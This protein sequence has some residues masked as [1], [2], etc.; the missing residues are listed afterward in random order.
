MNAPKPPDPVKT[1]EA[2]ADM[3]QA[4]AITQYGLGATNQV[5]PYGNLTYSQVGT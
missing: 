4:T 1:A 2:Q 3:N 5:T